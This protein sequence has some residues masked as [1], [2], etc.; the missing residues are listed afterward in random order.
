MLIC[1]QITWGSFKMQSL[2]QQVGVGLR[3]CFSNKGSGEA[4]DAGPGTTV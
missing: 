1:I 2:I 3:F 4:I